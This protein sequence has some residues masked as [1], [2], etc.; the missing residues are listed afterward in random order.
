MPRTASPSLHTSEVAERGRD[1]LRQP[2][3]SALDIKDEPSAGHFAL[4][5]AAAAASRPLVVSLPQLSLLELL[6][7]SHRMRSEPSGHACIIMWL[8]TGRHFQDIVWCRQPC[9]GGKTQ[10][11][12]R[13]AAQVYTGGREK[14]KEVNG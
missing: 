4:V 13:R 14:E 12:H 10:V 5:A 3:A 8:N 9:V 1:K 2:R 6:A 7:T 11:V